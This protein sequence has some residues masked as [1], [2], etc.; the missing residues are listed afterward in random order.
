MMLSLVLLLAPLSFSIKSKG[1]MVNCPISYE[2]MTCAY[3]LA[4]GFKAENECQL[5]VEI[6]LRE[7]NNRPRF[8]K[9]S[10]GYCVDDKKRQCKPMTQE[11]FT[12]ID[13]T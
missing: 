1:C 5:K 3:D 13:L 9:T 11:E 2:G 10:S 6:C 7:L 12:D 8:I 4:C